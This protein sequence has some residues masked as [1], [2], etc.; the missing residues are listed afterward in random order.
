MSEHQ[1]RLARIE[2]DEAQVE[3]AR[4]Y[5]A[6]LRRLAIDAPPHIASGLR[7]EADGIERVASATAERAAIARRYLSQLVLVHTQSLDTG[8]AG[9]EWRR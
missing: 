5:V 7:V 1:I 4:G 6:R 2:H 8:R 9:Q 3:I